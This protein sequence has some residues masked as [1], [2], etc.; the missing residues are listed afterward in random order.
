MPD[1]VRQTLLKIATKHR[2]LFEFAA[3]SLE[4]DICLVVAR[5]GASDEG[6]AAELARHRVEHYI[7][8]VSLL[9]DE[10]PPMAKVLVIHRSGEAD[11]A[12]RQFDAK[13]WITFVPKN[14]DDL[15][16][17][18]DSREQLF[19]RLRPF[20]VEVLDAGW[21][22]Y[23]ELFRQIL[24]SVRMFR[25]ASKTASYGMEYLYKWIAIEALTVAGNTKNKGATVAERIASLF[26]ENREAIR[27][28]VAELWRRRHVIGHEAKAEFFG[29]AEIENVFQLYI[30]RLDY[31]NT[32]VMV[33]AVDNK[34]RAATVS[35]LW[36]LANERI[37]PRDIVIERPK[38]A[39]RWG[40]EKVLLNC[41]LGWPGIGTTLDAAFD[42]G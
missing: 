20:F 3:P 32:A 1:N 16:P 18:E 12:F 22:Q 29:E 34:N 17:W 11:G 13:G 10:P 19:V 7:D 5:I 33:F 38:G 30:P 28:E 39:A 26:P 2:E 41:N 4:R 35:E 23:S 24:F 37:R 8:G 25:R 42:R 15:K 31:L 27:A 14:K 6:E 40:A 9:L 36:A 21:D